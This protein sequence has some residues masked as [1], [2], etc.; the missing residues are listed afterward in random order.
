LDLALYREI[1]DDPQFTTEAVALVVVVVALSALVAGV[2]SS[3]R[4]VLAFFAELASS[5]VLGWLLWVLISYLVGAGLGG[6]SSV[7]EMTCTL[8]YA[9]SPRLWRC[10]IS[11]LVSAGGSAPLPRPWGLRQA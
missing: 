5:L 9:N 6:R 11:S 10:S 2:P 8:G 1:A 7:T 4:F 3:R